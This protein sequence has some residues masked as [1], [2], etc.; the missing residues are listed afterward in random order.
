M[1]KKYNEYLRESFGDD[2]DVDYEEEPDVDYFI[3]DK[4]FRKFLIDNDC[5]K[6][7]CE[8]CLAK[9]EKYHGGG[10]KWSEN[11]EKLSKNYGRDYINM[12]L[13]WAD[14]PEGSGYWQ[15]LHYKWHEIVN[16]KALRETKIMLVKTLIKEFP[17][18]KIKDLRKMNNNDLNNLL[19]KK[20]YIRAIIKELPD[21]KIEDLE[22]FN[23]WELNDLVKKAKNSEKK[24]KISSVLKGTEKDFITDEE[25]KKFL[26]D[27]DC[28]DL[29]IK[30]C[31]RRGKYNF[32]E[33][34]GKIGRRE[35]FIR[36]AFNW[37]VKDAYWRDIHNKWLKQIGMDKGIAY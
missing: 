10:D 22:K 6:E 23:Y 37:G 28:Y 7:F 3:K 24:K 18:L 12:C 35:N 11:F 14:T 29:Y 13:N 2:D 4:E 33:N 27:N 26:K 5:L 1:I 17:E 9:E 25:F 31:Y 34:F 8:N 32:V 19:N 30:N 20:R 16:R 21:Q 15:T 36:R